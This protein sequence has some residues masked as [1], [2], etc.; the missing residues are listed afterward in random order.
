MKWILLL[1]L[2]LCTPHAQNDD[3]LR[4]SAD[5]PLTWDD[6]KPRAGKAGFYKA[7]AYTGMRYTVDAP[8]QQQVLIEVEPYFV[9]SQSWV[10]PEFKNDEL[11]RHEQ[12]H[13]DLTAIYAFKLDSALRPYEVGVQ[14][15]SENRLIEPVDSIFQ[16]LYAELQE[17][18]KRYDKETNHSMIDSAQ[19]RWTGYIASELARW[20]D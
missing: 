13:F 1:T 14:E 12:G 5:R 8:D 16:V 9:H 20:A 6:F 18:Q 19:K 10:H 15:F 17:T 11:L 2:A 3:E 7:F 4:W